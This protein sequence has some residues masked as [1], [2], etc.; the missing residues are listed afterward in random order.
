VAPQVG[1]EHPETPRQALFGEAAEAAAMGRDTVEA[2][3]GRGIRVAPLVDVQ[4]HAL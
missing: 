4:E 1:G 3:D 2:E